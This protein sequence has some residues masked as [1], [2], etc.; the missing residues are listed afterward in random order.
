MQRARR[1]DPQ[2]LD[3]WELAIRAQGHLARLT[4]ED[5]AEAL[6]LATESTRLNP[7]TTA[8]LNSPPSPTSTRRCPA[9][10]RPRATP[11]SPRTR[12]LAGR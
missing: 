11:S 1:K 12:R 9:G 6:R 10:A 8:G 5:N 7:G 2:A 3:A 4:R